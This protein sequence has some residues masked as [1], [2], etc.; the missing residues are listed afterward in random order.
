LK[1]RKQSDQSQHSA[2]QEVAYPSKVSVMEL[3]VLD[4]IASSQKNELPLFLLN[5]KS[6]KGVKP[7]SPKK[8]QK[9][10]GFTVF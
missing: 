4:I 8:K 7:L 2:C 6:C 1:R 10:M 5:E 9:K 3:G